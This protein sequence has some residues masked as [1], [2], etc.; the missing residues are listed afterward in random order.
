MACVVLL[1]GCGGGTANNQQIS[2]VQAKTLAYGEQAV[3]QVAG[4][5]LR[6]GMAADTGI[7][8][9]PVF[10]TSQSVPQ[11]AILNCTVTATGPQ[12]ITITGTDGQVLY[13]GTVTVPL[14]QVTLFTS[15][16]NMLLELDPVAAPVTVNNF[17]SY[18]RSGYYTN[19]LFHRVIAGFVAQGGGYTTGM[20]KK[21]G[22]IAPIA[23]ETS[24]QG[25]RNV[26]NS[27][28]MARTNDPNSATSEFFINLAD[29]P[30][31]DFQ[32]AASPGYAVFGKVVQGVDI[33]AAIGAVPTATTLGVADVPVS[34]VIIQFA[35]RVK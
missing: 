2:Q 28:A 26:H 34:D 16:G 4:A 5:D 32:S 12:P 14:P 23:L 15:M 33:A 17:L 10:N 1:A 27:V 13:R 9:D 20:V 24:N 31:L 18:V 19:T 8:K 21:A 22:Q 30:S 29:N 11:L 25:L 7:C 6:S 3:I 35:L